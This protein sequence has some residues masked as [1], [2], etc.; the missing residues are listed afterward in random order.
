MKTNG[1]SGLAVMREHESTRMLALG[2]FIHPR[3]RRLIAMKEGDLDV[4]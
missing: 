1:L 4:I 3:C 2:T